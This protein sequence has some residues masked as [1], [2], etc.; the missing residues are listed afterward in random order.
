MASLMEE[1]LTTMNSEQT[2]YQQLSEM[3]LEK[4]EIIIHGQVDLLDAISVKEQGVADN[5]KQLEKRRH[6]LLISIADVTGL[7]KDDVTVTKIIEK[8][9]GRPEDQQALTS[10]RDSLVE[11][12]SK[13]Q[14]LNDQNQILLQQSLELVDFDLTLMKSMR[15]APVTANYNRNAMDTGTVLPSSGFDAKQ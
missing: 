11:I 9:S 12:A 15:Q 6:N 3:A 5:L 14:F 2:L 13:M 7:N 8:L 1:L 10:A 4:K